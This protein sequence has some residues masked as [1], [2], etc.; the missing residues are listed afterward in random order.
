MSDLFEK[1]EAAVSDDFITSAEKKELKSLFRKE[2]E[3]DHDAN[4]IRSLVFDLAMEKATSENYPAILG[5][6]EEMNKLIIA[7]RKTVQVKI[8]E[9]IY[10]S[11]GEDCL[12]AILARIRSS[13]DSIKVCVFTIS[14]NRISEALIK[15]HR[16]GVHI[17]VITDNDKMFD[18]GSDVEMLEEAGIKVKIDL[19]DKHMHHKFAVFDNKYALTGS[20]NWTRSAEK[21]NHENILISNAE[22]TVKSFS[23]AFDKLWDEMEWLD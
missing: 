15:A 1:L 17:K 9:S 13:K 10:Y 2:I 22:K 7:A 12:D 6:V 21:Y 19:T 5:W 4:L 14:D 16:R 11:P 3:S 23:K 20:Y 8:E 18:K